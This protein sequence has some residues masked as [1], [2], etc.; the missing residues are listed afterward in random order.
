MENEKKLLHRGRDYPFYNKD[1]IK[2]SMC[3][4]EEEV[5]SWFSEEDLK[6]FPDEKGY[7]G[8]LP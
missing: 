7:T 5:K 1:G 8:S 6:G 4:D 2:M 3:M